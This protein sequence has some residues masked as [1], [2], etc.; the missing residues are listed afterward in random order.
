MDLMISGFLYYMFVYR[1]YA[2][3]KRRSLAPSVV[4]GT[5]SSPAVKPCILSGDDKK[6]RKKHKLN[7]LEVS[8]Y[9]LK[10]SP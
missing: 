4:G 9:F 8:A 6:L 10:F 2:F 3:I 7:I 5:P 1:F